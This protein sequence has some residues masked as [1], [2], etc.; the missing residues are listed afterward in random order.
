MIVVAWSVVPLSSPFWWIVSLG[1]VFVV[2]D[3]TR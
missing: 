1:L 2:L 3:G